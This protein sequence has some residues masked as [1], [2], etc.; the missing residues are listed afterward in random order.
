M[1]IPREFSR[2]LMAFIASKVLESDSV[3]NP[4]ELAKACGLFT[5]R[6]FGVCELDC[7]PLGWDVTG[8]DAW[9]QRLGKH[10][11]EFFSNHKEG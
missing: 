9:A 10:V 8:L 11:G 5:R 3:V 1:K 6:W 2:E 4:N 7:P